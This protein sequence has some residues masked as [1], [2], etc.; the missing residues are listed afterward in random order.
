[1]DEGFVRRNAREPLAC[2]RSS[3]EQSKSDGAA[4]SLALHLIALSGNVNLCSTAG[5]STLA[6]WPGFEQSQSTFHS[7]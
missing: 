2:E 4:S 6:H 5:L 1:M 3:P 7:K